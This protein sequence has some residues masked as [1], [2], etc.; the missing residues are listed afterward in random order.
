MLMSMNAAA[1]M[2]RIFAGSGFQNPRRFTTMRNTIIA[3]VIKIGGFV[4]RLTID[5]KNS[6]TS[7]TSVRKFRHLYGLARNELPLRRLPL[8]E[9]QHNAKRRIAATLQL[10]QNVRLKVQI[11]HHRQ[12]APVQDRRF[13]TGLRLDLHYLKME[14]HVPCW[15]QQ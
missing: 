13:S 8:L 14:S 3:V 1:S 10:R 11:A 5:L 12:R 9:L 15:I 7:P 4:R 6:I 2:K